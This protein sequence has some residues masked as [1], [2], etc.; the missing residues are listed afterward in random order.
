MYNFNS[1]VIQYVNG[2]VNNYI[3]DNIPQFNIPFQ[4]YKIVNKMSKFITEKY[5]RFLTQAIEIRQQG[6]E[7]ENE[8][9]YFFNESQNDINNQKL[10]EDIA[11]QKYYESQKKSDESDQLFDKLNGAQDELNQIYAVCRISVNLLHNN[12]NGDEESMIIYFNLLK[13]LGIIR[14]T[15][16]LIFEKL[17]E[18]LEESLKYYQ[19]AQIEYTNAVTQ[20]NTAYTTNDKLLVDLL[21]SYNDQARNYCHTSRVLK[22]LGYTQVSNR[23]LNNVRTI[24][25]D[26]ILNKIN[27]NPKNMLVSND[28]P[29]I[30][31]DYAM[32]LIS[33]NYLGGASIYLTKADD[34]IKTKTTG[35]VVKSYLDKLLSGT[36]FEGYVDKEMGPYNLLAMNIKRELDYVLKT[37]TPDKYFYLFGNKQTTYTIEYFMP[38][39]NYDKSNSKKEVSSKFL[40]LQY[41]Q[42]N[43]YAEDKSFPTQVRKLTIKTSKRLDANLYSAY[44]KDPLS[45]FVVY[46]DKAENDNF[47]TSVILQVPTVINKPS[48]RAS[49]LKPVI[50]GGGKTFQIVYLDDYGNIETKNIDEGLLS[51]IQTKPEESKVL[52]AMSKV[53]SSVLKMGGNLLKYLW[54]KSTVLKSTNKPSKLGANKIEYQANN[55]NNAKK[56]N[57]IVP[58]EL[59]IELNTSIPGFQKIQYTPKMTLRDTNESTIRFDPLTKLDLSVINRIPKDL[60]VKEFFNKG[61]FESLVN[62]HGMEKVRSLLEAMQE[63]IVT[64][65][66]HVTLRVLFGINTP[67][68]INGEVYYIADVQ[69]TPGDWTVDVK[70]KPVTFDMN[71]IQNPYVYSS[72]VNDDI[73]SGQQQINNLPKNLITGPNYNGPPPQKYTVAR[74]LSPLTAGP[75]LGLGLGSPYSNLRPYQNVNPYQNYRPTENLIPVKSTPQPSPATATATATAPIPVP[76]VKGDNPLATVYFCGGGPL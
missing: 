67:I 25:I 27:L 60:R 36:W 37:T 15:Q 62:F 38:G 56:V 72:L 73:I 53:G 20:L 52:N 3:D 7:L 12:I 46:N 71:K 16:G 47:L 51:I 34:A 40:F 11:T 18:I 19:M 54:S 17:E 26:N 61:L 23:L 22:K 63:G 24:F 74:G 35:N 4:F 43:N 29:Q 75:G 31:Y 6:I 55:A 42:Q 5:R 48:L 50:Y 69:W 59:K 68:Y 70:Q 21:Y 1:R 45:Y 64:N 41:S 76:A 65:N 2:V 39:A 8:S 66:I 14:E 58:N 32:F 13:K 30:Y 49:L 33:Q 44:S 9:I 57:E 10:Y 28:I